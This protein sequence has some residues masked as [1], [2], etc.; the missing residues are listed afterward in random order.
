[1]P[2]DLYRSGVL[3]FERLRLTAAT[4]LLSEL[5]S[6]TA[7]NVLPLLSDLAGLKVHSIGTS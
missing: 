5:P 1:M 2:E 7:E 4:H 3:A 6:L